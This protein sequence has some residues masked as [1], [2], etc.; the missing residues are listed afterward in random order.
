[1]TQQAIFDATLYVN[2]EVIPYMPNSL[3]IIGGKGERVV[4]AQVSGG[5]GTENVVS[6][7]V[8][9]KKG[10][11]SFD[12]KSTIQNKTNVKGWSRNFDAN[13]IRIV[14]RDGISFIYQNAVLINDPEFD[15]GADGIASCEF[16]S[17]P[18]IQG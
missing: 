1:M 6:E 9:T 16:E 17:L 18:E 8:E 13:V 11:V 5:G 12:L 14:H 15:L 3:K 10:K 2:N 4:S 7:N